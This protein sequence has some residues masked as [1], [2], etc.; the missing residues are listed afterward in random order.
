[1]AT[2]ER[3]IPPTIAA[4]GSVHYSSVTSAPDDSIAVCHMVPDRIIPVIFLPG[5]MGTN[6]T[7]EGRPDAIWLLDSGTTV[8]PWMAT[9]PAVRKQKL[10]PDQTEVYGGGKILSGTVQAE[11]ELRRRGWGEVASMSYGEWLVWLENA[12]ND[13]HAGTDYG[14]GGLRAELMKQLVAEAPGVK[15]LTHDEVA[16]T[17]R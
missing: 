1:M 8:A 2:V 9:S 7:R 14:R 13:S 10:N 6:L 15:L 16:L 11:G 17:Y 3:I 4:D 5:V 12:L